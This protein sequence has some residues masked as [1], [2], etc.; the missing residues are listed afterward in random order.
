MIRIITKGICLTLGAVV[1][2]FAVRGMVV[3]G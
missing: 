2:G 1:G 3:R